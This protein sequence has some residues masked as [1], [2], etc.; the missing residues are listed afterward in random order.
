M[1]EKSH[2]GGIKWFNAT[3]SPGFIVLKDSKEAM[4]P[5]PGIQLGEHKCREENLIVAF[6]LVIRPNGLHA[7]NVIPFE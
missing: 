6:S 1:S 4:V 5:F 2:I 7:I 3:K